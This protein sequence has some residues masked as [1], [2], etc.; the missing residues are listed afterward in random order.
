MSSEAL[1]FVIVQLLAAA[2]GILVGAYLILVSKRNKPTFP[3]G[4]F[5]FLFSL[6]IVPSILKNLNVWQELPLLHWLPLRNIWLLSPLFFLYTQRVSI[7]KRSN[8]VYWM[9]LPG[10]LVLVLKPLALFVPEQWLGLD[11]FNRDVSQ[12]SFILGHGYCFFIGFLNIRYIDAH[13]AEVN[14]VFSSVYRKELKWARTF[15]VFGL[16]LCALSL[17]IL[18][19]GT[20]YQ[21][22]HLP[23]VV[24]LLLTVYWL[25]F[26]GTKQYSVQRVLT[27]PTEY[28]LV[29][30]PRSK[31]LKPQKEPKEMGVMMVKLQDYFHAEKPYTDPELNIV[32][33]AVALGEHP[34]KLSKAINVFTGKNFNRFVNTY[35]VNKAKELLVDPSKANITMEGVGSEVGFQS[36]SAFYSAFKSVTGTTPLAFQKRPETAT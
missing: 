15:V 28:G 30:R 35:R 8:R 21:W 29:L 9:F 25:S 11:N 10:L 33:V 13:I 31:A 27:N 23:F 2:Q 5:L 12:I 36:K 32:E 19:S 20:G 3:L 4:I 18:L 6:E 14:E 24:I 17:G 16:L 1:I 7:F 22:T 26:Y 34:K